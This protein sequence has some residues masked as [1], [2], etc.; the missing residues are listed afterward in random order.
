METK[1]VAIIGI[2]VLES[3]ALITHTDGAFFMP[4]VGV[5]CV[6]AGY[7]LRIFKEKH[8]HGYK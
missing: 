2:V 7:E 8:Q 5:I 4:V 1:D 3:V 6:L